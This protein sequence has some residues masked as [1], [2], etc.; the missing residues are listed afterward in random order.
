MR[1]LN[2]KKAKKELGRLISDITTNLHWAN[3][4]FLSS[5]N[6][7]YNSENYHF[8]KLCYYAYRKNQIRLFEEFGI[9]YYSVES[10]MLDV[11][12]DKDEILRDHEQAYQDWQKAKQKEVA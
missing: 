8:S 3:E 11:M 5:D 2:S 6:D 4:Y 12:N 10:S 9:S 1:N 7:D